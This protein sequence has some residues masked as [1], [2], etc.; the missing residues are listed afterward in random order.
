MANQDI[1][2]GFTSGTKNNLFIDA[3][4]YFKNFIYGTDTFTSALAAGKC[5]G[6]TQGGGSFSAVPKMRAIQVDGVKGAAKGLQ[7]ID[8]WEVKMSAN[9]LEVSADSIKNALAAFENTVEADGF[10]DKIEARNY[11]LDDDYIDNIAFVGKIIGTSKPIIIIIKNVLNT[12]G[13]TLTPQD[14]KEGLIQLEFMAHYDSTDLDSPPFEIYHP[15]SEGNISGTVTDG[16]T[17]VA[18]ATVTVT[19]DGETFTTTTAATT[20]AYL[21][22]DLPYGAVTVTATKDAKTGTDTGTVVAGATTAFGAIA[23]A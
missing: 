16:G 11:I 13:L 7:V 21:L 5:I 1:Y 15:K 19:I 8:S 17:P 4:V 14:N 22:E 3:G 12:K 6:A 18:G 9:I 2:G 20:G 23:I 10:Y